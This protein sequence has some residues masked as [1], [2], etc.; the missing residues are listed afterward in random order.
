V[1]GC[2]AAERRRAAATTVLGGGPDGPRLGA[3]VHPEASPGW[4]HRSHSNQRACSTGQRSWRGGAGSS[5]RRG[6]TGGRR[7]KV[8]R[9]HGGP[10][11]GRGQVGG[12]AEE[13]DRA[14]LELSGQAASADLEELH[15]GAP[16]AG[17][18][19]GGA[20]GAAGGVARAGPHGPAALA[21]KAPGIHAPRSRGRTD[22]RRDGR[23]AGGGRRR[24]RRRAVGEGRAVVEA[25]QPSTKRHFSWRAIAS[26][27]RSAGGRPAR[28]SPRGTTL[29]GG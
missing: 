26:Y 8:E 13:G 1:R 23:R 18:R 7:S 10:V 11:I 20:G 15:S 19:A 12:A 5:R 22:R 24:R 25:A 16:Q 6:R 2:R 21:L 28:P 29:W 9:P 14:H 27:S 17:E 4:D 3:E